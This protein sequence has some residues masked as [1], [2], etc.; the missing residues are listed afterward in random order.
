MTYN[1]QLPINCFVIN[2]KE[3]KERWERVSQSFSSISG[4]NLIRVDA[5]DGSLLDFPHKDYAENSYMMF[6]GK[7][8]NPREVGC[9][10]S[11]IKTLRMF[12]ETDSQYALICEDDV[13]VSNHLVEVLE[14]AVRY[15]SV[16][17]L[18]RLISFRTP[19]NFLVRGLCHGYSLRVPVSWSGGTGAYFVNRNAAEGII[20]YGLPMRCPYDHLL[21][22]QNWRMGFKVA[23]IKPY[24]VILNDLNY[25]ST[26]NAS[27][28]FKMPFFKRYFLT[29]T[30]PYRGYMALCRLTKQ[31]STVVNNLI[32]RNK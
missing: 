5:I 9:Y 3:S 13:S 27:H 20:K 23:M 29:M 7:K 11:H 15:R 18:L 24:P 25:T 2:L 32:H 14:E 26:I 28:S 4:I 6:H 12:L 30:L 21:F 22:E 16:W 1:L 8:T 10:F 17:D 19:Y 31:Y